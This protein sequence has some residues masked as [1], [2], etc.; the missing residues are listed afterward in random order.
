MLVLWL[1]Y[2]ELLDRVSK[3]SLGLLI[4]V[5]VMVDA[6]E[7]FLGLFRAVVGS[8]SQMSFESKGAV[9][10]AYGTRAMRG[11]ERAGSVVAIVAIVDCC[12]SP[13]WWYNSGAPKYAGAG[14][15][16][17]VMSGDDGTETE[18]AIAGRGAK[19][20]GTL[21]RLPSWRM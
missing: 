18:A 2:E 1:P 11:L 15:W 12:C 3:L 14:P 5:T 9:C 6:W 20:P 19:R 21:R 7:S 10:K 16:L 4:L 8:D 17:A 13:L